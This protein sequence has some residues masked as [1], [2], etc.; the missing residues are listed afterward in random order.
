MHEAERRSVDLFKSLEEIAVV[1][2]EVP[3]REA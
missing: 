2:D 1:D 3:Q